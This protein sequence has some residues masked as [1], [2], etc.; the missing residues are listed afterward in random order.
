VAW[1]AEEFWGFRHGYAGTI[2]KGQG[3]TL[4]HTYLYHTEHWRR[5]ASYVALTRQRETAQVFVARETAP[6]VAELAR[7][8][9]RDEIRAASIA[10]KARED[11]Q[12]PQRTL[13]RDANADLVGPEWAE[14]DLTLDDAA[15]LLSPVYAKR[16]A[17][18][19]TTKDATGK[20]QKDFEHWK[21][22]RNRRRHDGEE[23]WKE[24]TWTQK[25]AHKRGWR[26]DPEMTQAES[27]L[28]RATAMVEKTATK[29]A[30]LRDRLAYEER[31]AA[32][33]FEKVRPEAE[34]ELARRQELGRNARTELRAARQREIERDRA[35]GW[36]HDW[37]ISRGWDR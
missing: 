17:A 19:D 5:A 34:A 1:S 11:T 29:L 32:A 8:M 31:R 35:L 4:D 36:E 15:R 21:L 24:L 14:Q 2:Y 22:E 25:L 28:G 10:W 18:R 26:P 23:R 33:A 9:A 7:Q 16:A 3:K 12:D 20:A 6:D 37:R 30:T 13:Q 27:G